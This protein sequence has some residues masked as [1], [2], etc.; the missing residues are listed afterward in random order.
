V[1][2]VLAG[3]M[4]FLVGLVALLIARAGGL[5]SATPPGAVGDGV[6]LAGGDTAVLL[7]VLALVVASFALLR[8]LCLRAL[9]RRSESARR[10]ESPAAD[11]AAVALSVVMCVLAV[12]VWALNPYAALLLVP[13]LHLWLWLAQPGARSRRWSVA[14]LL[15][16]PIVP[17]LLVLFYYANAYGLSPVGLAWSLA[18]L[19]GGAVSI[20][21]A[22]YWAVALGCLA[23]AIVIGFRA[24]RAAATTPEPAVTVR[25]PSSYAGP[26]SLGGTKSAL[27]R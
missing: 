6:K 1:G 27:R 4:P 21:T 26:G 10:P 5:L 22:L 11:A 2:W 20:V 18:L 12:I 16:L 13:A 9:A 14:L 23:S 15:L 7:T 8:P 19:P 17:A 3:V 25:G 24:A